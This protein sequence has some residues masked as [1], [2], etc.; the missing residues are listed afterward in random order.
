ML[1]GRL[2]ENEGPG[3]RAQSGLMDGVGVLPETISRGKCQKSNVAI[4]CN[5]RETL[6][7]KRKGEGRRV[8]WFN[9]ILVPVGRELVCSLTVSRLGGIA[10]LEAHAFEGS[11]TLMK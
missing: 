8:D 1:E 6:P 5:I 10:K 11:L 7:Y 4:A 3:G 2:G 9:A